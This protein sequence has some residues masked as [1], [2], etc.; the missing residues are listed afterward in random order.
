MTVWFVLEN[1]RGYGA[2]VAD[3]FSSLESAEAYLLG[4]NGS[5]CYL[6]SDVGEDVQG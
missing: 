2:S 1:D 3:V 5:N 6:D 4:P